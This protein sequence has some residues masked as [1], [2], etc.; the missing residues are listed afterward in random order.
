M[1][2]RTAGRARRRFSS[3]MRLCPPASTWAS[4]PCSARTGAGLLEAGGTDV[5]E[6]SRLHGCSSVRGGDL[7]GDAR[8]EHPDGGEAVDEAGQRRAVGQQGSEGGGGLGDPAG[9]GQEHAAP[10]GRLPVVA[11]Q[12]LGGGQ[13]VEDPGQLR[14]V[15]VAGGLEQRSLFEEDAADDGEGPSEETRRR[16]SPRGSGWSSTRSSNRMPVQGWPVRSPLTTREMGGLAAAGVARPPR[17]RPWRPTCGRPCRSAGRRLLVGVDHGA[18]HLVSGQHVALGG[19]PVPDTVAGVGAHRLPVKAAARPAASTMPTWRT[20]WWGS[21]RRRASRTSGAGWSARSRSRPSGPYCREAKAWLADG[22]HAGLG[23]RGDAAHAVEVRLEAEA[24]HPGVG[25]SGH[26]RVGHP[27]HPPCRLS[28]GTLREVT[29]GLS[30]SGGTNGAVVLGACS[31]MTGGRAWACRGSRRGRPDGFRPDP[32]I[33]RRR[34]S[35]PRLTTVFGA[36]PRAGADGGSRVAVPSSLW[37]SG[38]WPGRLRGHQGRAADVACAAPP[39]W[40]RAQ[41]SPVAARAA[42]GPARQRPDRR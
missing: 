30:L 25:V 6:G 40:W 31:P 38:P 42:A 27:L 9:P 35:P 34:P 17:R 8:G 19:H 23:E 7:V 21:R 11:G 16:S 32:H 29:L 3:G 5:A 12:G 4:P 10:Q 28:S 36:G 18:P 2:T 14:L 39:P 13:V 26:D 15:D 41:R 1:S 33:S 24:D 37:S 22:A 20:S